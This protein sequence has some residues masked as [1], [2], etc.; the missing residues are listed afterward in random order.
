MP[1]QNFASKILK[2]SGKIF[3]KIIFLVFRRMMVLGKNLHTEI[4]SG[5]SLSH[6]SILIEGLGVKF[7]IY[8]YMPPIMV[9]SLDFR[10]C[11]EYICYQIQLD[12]TTASTDI[13]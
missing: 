5:V 12:D 11:S 9:G 1:L 3:A 13:V 10:M 7:Q 8:R 2:L 6:F 4:I